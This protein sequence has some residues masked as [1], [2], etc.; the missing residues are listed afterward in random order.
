[1]ICPS[2]KVK[3]WEKLTLEPDRTE[4]LENLTSTVHGMWGMANRL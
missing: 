3:T 4:I 2:N 1:M